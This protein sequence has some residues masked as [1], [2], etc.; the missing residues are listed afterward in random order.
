MLFLNTDMSLSSF[1]TIPS[2]KRA[3]NYLSEAEQSIIID[4]YLNNK[5]NIDPTLASNINLNDVYSSIVTLK[6]TSPK[7]LKNFF[8][9]ITPLQNSSPRTETQPLS[10]GCITSPLPPRTI[11]AYTD[12]AD[13][14]FQTYRQIISKKKQQGH[15]III[16]LGAFPFER[17]HFNFESLSKL[18]GK[19]PFV[20]YVD[21]PV[22]SKLYTNEGIDISPT[23]NE[24][25]I[26]GDFNDLMF[27][28]TIK[29]ILK[30][31]VNLIIA[32]ASVTKFINLN[33][34]S[35]SLWLDLLDQNGE[36]ILDYNA[37]MNRI[38][39]ER[40]EQDALNEVKEYYS[41]SDNPQSIYSKNKAYILKMKT[42]FVN[43]KPEEW[44]ID[45][46]SSENTRL[47]TYVNKNYPQYFRTWVDTHLG[48]YYT[49]KFIFSLKTEPGNPYWSDIR[50]YDSDK[51]FIHIRK[52]NPLPIDE[53]S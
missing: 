31:K 18:S 20:I 17:N 49:S 45:Y 6:R 23:K 34:Y 35:F 3:F 29:K 14:S 11:Q 19:S 33:A 32:D 28:E 30:N 1:K 25:L 53:K 26:T 50:R 48:E 22:T 2:I 41:N 16:V 5:E 43:K 12:E 42:I 13:K 8:D 27:L 51:I 21:S 47:I 15:P 37:Q 38:L 4:A 36:L 46:S 39:T 10:P 40:T 24:L 9:K 44:K 7:D 52:N